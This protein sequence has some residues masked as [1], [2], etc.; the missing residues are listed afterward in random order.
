[1]ALSNPTGSYE[2]AGKIALVTGAAAGI[3]RAI[4]EA[5]AEQGAK[6]ALVDRDPAVAELPAALAG[7]HQAFVLDVRQD[8]AVEARCRLSSSASAAWTFS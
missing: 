4:A 8:D 2:L 3:G 1:M 5:F 6:L 7:D